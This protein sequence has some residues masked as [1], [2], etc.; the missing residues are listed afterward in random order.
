MRKGL[1]IVDVQNDYF[2]GGAM[3]LSGMT[4]AAENCRK[5]L[6]KFRAARAAVVHVQHCSVQPGAHFF[7]PETQGGAIHA[8]VRP[9]ASEAVVVK[10]YPNAFRETWLADVLC[11]ACVA[12]L[13]VCGAMTHTCIDSTVRAAFDLGYVCTVASD[14]CATRD[15]EWDGAVVKAA[16]VQAA[17]LA[18]LQ[19]PFAQVRTTKD[20]LG[21][22]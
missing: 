1:V 12:E 21:L 9:T 15:L 6:Q 4:E 2:P 11:R 13:V 3:E 22:A 20:L 10:L 14:A 5:L 7:I 17:F 19:L 16:E 18:A 8:G